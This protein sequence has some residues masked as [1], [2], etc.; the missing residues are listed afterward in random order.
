MTQP[1]FYSTKI[2]AHKSAIEIGE[3][4][5]KYGARRFQLEYDTEGEPSTVAFGMEVPG[6]EREVPVRLQAQIRGLTDRLYGE[7]SDRSSKTLVDCQAQALRIA[8]RQLKAQ[9]AL[10]LE[11]VENGV[12]PFHEAFMADIL[13]EGG[14]RLADEFMKQ[15]SHLLPPPEE[16][17]I[18]LPVGE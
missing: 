1:M 14:V 15:S 6:F 4:V 18:A 8:W 11:L 13:L 9:V 12:R 7:L 5:R 10:T 2:P 17:V 3:M 16:N